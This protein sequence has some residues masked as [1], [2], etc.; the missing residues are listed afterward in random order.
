MAARHAEAPA[1][2]TTGRSPVCRSADGPRSSDPDAMPATSWFP[3]ICR[4]GSPARDV[5]LAPAPRLRPMRSSNPD[6]AGPRGRRYRASAGPPV[7]P[8][9]HRP[10]DQDPEARKGRPPEGEPPHPV[11]RLADRERPAPAQSFSVSSGTILNRSPTRPR[12]ATW[13]IG[14]S[15]S[16]L[17]AMM[18]FESF[19]PARC[20]IAPEM[21]IAT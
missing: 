2:S 16:L 1:S 13:K 19:M 15:S 10:G 17:M 12:S 11:Q 8:A 21:P 9:R 7:R 4:T 18:V 14:A 6:R 3:A 20:W 5:R